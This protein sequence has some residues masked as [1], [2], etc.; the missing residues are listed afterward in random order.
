MSLVKIDL[1]VGQ[2]ASVC[3]ENKEQRGRNHQLFE[4]GSWTDHVLKVPRRR[5]RCQNR[6]G[7]LECE[8]GCG[9]AF[10]TTFAIGRN[11]INLA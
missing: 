2:T 3:A 11:T 7:G 4:G 8:E 10:C 9:F 1:L 6:S 5:D